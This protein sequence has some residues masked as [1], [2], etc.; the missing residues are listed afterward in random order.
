M[1]GCG[2]VCNDL[3]MVVMWCL[4]VVCCICI[5]LRFGCYLCWQIEFVLLVFFF[6]VCVIIVFVFFFQYVFDFVENVIVIFEKEQLY[7]VFGFKDDEYVC[8]KEIFGCCFILGEL[9]MYLVMWLE[10]CFYKLSKNYLCCF[11]QKVF[12]EMKEWFMVGMGQ[13]VGVVDVG[14][15]WVVIFKVELYNYF[16]FIEFFQGVVIGV[17][18]IVCDIILMGVCL[19]VV[20]D[21][22][23]FGVIDY[24]DIVCVVYGVISG[25]SFYG[26]CLGFLNIG[27]EMV[28][29]FVYQVNFFVNVFVVGVLCYE[30]FK[31]VNVIGVGNKVVFFGVCMGGDGI[32]GVSILVF[33]MFVDGGFIKCF[34]VQVG[35]F[36]VEKVFIECCLELY[37]GEFVEVIQ[38]LGV[39]G[40]LCVISEFVVNGNSGMKVFFDNVL[41]CD[42]MF[43]VEEIFMLELQE[44]MMV[45]VVFEKFDVFLVVVNKWEVEIF[46]FG[47]VIGDGCF[48]IDWQGECIVDV[49]F[50]IVVVDGFVYDCLVVYLMWIDVLQVDVVENL[51]CFFELVVLCEQFFN[52]VVFLNFVDMSW[53]MNQY[54]YYVFG[55][56]VLSFFDD[57]GMI[58]VDEE[59]GLGFFIVIDVNGCYCQFDL[60]VGVQLV[61]VEVYC[62]VVVMG[63]V[64]MVIIDCLNFG[65]FENFEVMWQFGQIVDGFVDGCYELGILVIGGNVL[66]YNQIGDVLIYL[67][68]F[69]GV[70]GIIDDVFCCILFG[71][72]DEGQNIYLFGIMLIEFLGFVWVEV[73]YQYFGGLF[74]K[75]DFVG[76][77]CFVGLFV[78]VC[79]EWFIFLV[80]DFFEGGF[81]QVLVEG[82]MCFGVGVCV[83]LNEIIECDGVDV[84]IV[85]FFELIGCVF[86]IVL[87]ED[88]VKFCGFCEGCGYFVVCI[89]V[90]DSELQFEVQDVFIVLVVEFCEC[91]QVMLLLYFGLIVMELVV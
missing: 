41:L 20:M 66:F 32:G 48:I 63:V 73:V 47:E 67:I 30:D 24:F 11:G 57:V 83:W 39:V 60:Y 9:V 35:D 44:C 25:I 8:I 69:V 26:N 65:F 86:V 5:G 17:G 84:V 37:C 59:F 16:F 13:N 1:D 58:C 89:G 14:E 62:N 23:C 72:Q 22:L 27:G 87:C 33:D 85:L 50:L 10:Y 64:L 4:Y 91:L 18:G 43:M 68:L 46:V 55:N 56:M 71:W 90:M 45:I 53:I 77:K 61:F 36:F 74:L 15:G 3:M 70:F 31:F 42:F 19:V 82:V 28:F 54:D 79:D 38:D 81:V 6:G 78:V 21:V 40:I 76:E 88:D 2:V 7:G 12:D 29:D 75:V 34:V 51:L 80:Y 52:F 49:D